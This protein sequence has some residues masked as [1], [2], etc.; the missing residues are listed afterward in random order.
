MMAVPHP[1]PYQGSKRN[2]A[3]AIIAC[4]PE[5]AERLVEP[6]AGSAAV[7][8]AAAYHGKA[9]H[10]L[11]NDVNMPLMDLWRN[12]I[13]KPDDLADR[14]EKLWKAQL[15]RERRFYD[16]VRCRFNRTLR[17]YYLLYLLARC[18]KASVRYNANGEFNQSPDNRRKGRQP[19][20][21]RRDIKAA[22]SLLQG[23]SKLMSVDFRQVLK[24]TTP[25]DIVYMD[26]PYQGISVN[27]DPR[28][29]EGVDFEGFVEVL[30]ELNAK[31]I[32][33]I[34]SYDGR[35]GKK[36][37]GQTLPDT[38]DLR[39]VELDAGRSSQATLLGR[40]SKTYESLYLSPAL[41]A[42][43][44]HVRASQV[45]QPKQLTLLGDFT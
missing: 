45:A 14:Y 19:Q 17:P 23:R 16:L 1:I 32:S 20:T 21:M 39:R 10:F 7:S 15:G 44:G 12:I 9:Q 8:L 22:S 30:D 29:I 2:L 34:A 42:R 38:L 5:D 24:Q 40:R 18:V 27:R 28:Y 33:F 41:I 36:T 26:P 25:G 37:F 13:D 35:T 43:L 6:F 11:L 31:D 4:F 3:P